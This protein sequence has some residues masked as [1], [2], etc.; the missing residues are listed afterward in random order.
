MNSKGQM[1][2]G[3][4]PFVLSGICETFC[5]DE[6]REKDDSRNE[7]KLPGMFDLRLSLHIHFLQYQGA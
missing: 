5:H 3:V 4:C 1:P 6:R 7:N 2:T